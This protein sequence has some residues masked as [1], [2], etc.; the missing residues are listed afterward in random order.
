MLFS[1]GLTLLTAPPA[2]RL[3]ILTHSEHKPTCPLKLLGQTV[4]LALNKST[5]LQEIPQSAS[6]KTYSQLTS[7]P[8]YYLVQETTFGVVLLDVRAN[9]IPTSVQEIHAVIK[10]III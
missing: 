9:I 6:N 8:D 2:C 1:T 7:N 5:E 10:I 3:L 4:T